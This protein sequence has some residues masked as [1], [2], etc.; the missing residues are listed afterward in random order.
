MAAIHERRI[1]PKNCGKAVAEYAHPSTLPGISSHNEMTPTFKPSNGQANSAFPTSNASHQGYNVNIQVAR[2]D[3]TIL[4]I[5][6]I[7]LSEVNTSNNLSCMLY[8]VKH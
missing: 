6:T 4:K 7:N 3:I 8:G 5:F 1:Q 2:M